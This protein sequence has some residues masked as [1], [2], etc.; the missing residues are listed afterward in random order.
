MNIIQS[1]YF[2]MAIAIVGFFCLWYFWLRKK[3]A[4]KGESVALTKTVNKEGKPK[5]GAVTAMVLDNETR[6][7]YYNVQ[8][9][10]ED[11]EKIISKHKSLGRQWNRDGKYTYAL[12]KKSE[13]DYEPVYIAPNS[14]NDP[15][16]LHSE[17]Q[18]PYLE[19]T[20]DMRI[21][22]NFM[23]KYGGWIWLT[24]GALGAISLIMMSRG[25]T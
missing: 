1:P 3:K 6:R 4:H 24:V 11:V 20:M 10:G 17:L 14:E 2:A 12:I 19:Q 25:G 9:N 21:K 23:Q 7:G 18:H 16:K 22:Q 15:T 13:N 8:I 5:Y